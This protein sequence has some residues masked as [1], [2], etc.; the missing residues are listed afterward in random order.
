VDFKTKPIDITS[1]TVDDSIQVRERLDED[2]VADLVSV[3]EDNRGSSL[4]PI[5]VFLGGNILWLADG[6][7]RMAAHQKANSQTIRAEV[8]EGNKDKAKLF[9]A[10][11]NTRNGMRLLPGDKK[12]AVLLALSTPDGK[13]LSQV[14]LAR[15]IGCGQSFISQ[16]I[17]GGITTNT[18]PSS[19]SSGRSILRARIDAAIR[20]DPE[21]SNAAISQRLSCDHHTVAKRRNEIGLHR[22]RAGKEKEAIEYIKAH[23]DH[24]NVHISKT[25]GLHHQTIAKIKSKLG[26]QAH[27]RGK[28]H[29]APEQHKKDARSSA[30]V[31]RLRPPKRE[32][33][34]ELRTGSMQ[35]IEKMSA[36]GRWSHA[37]ELSNRWSECFALPDP[38]KVAAGQGG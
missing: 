13:K 23:P 3:I 1:I 5:V 33:D 8:R 35:S 28:L 21:E 22:S 6:F 20:A 2:Y 24:S 31:I 11:A 7:H 27:P 4:P 10:S 19:N 17:S 34:K 12:R 15:L 30:E 26:V 16:V 14:D 25:C 9:A 32:A 38:A 37:V 18:P 29:S 36:E